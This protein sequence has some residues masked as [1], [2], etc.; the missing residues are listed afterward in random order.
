V[1]F[2]V[3]AY[4][5]E[6]QPGLK[7]GIENLDASETPKVTVT[8]TKLYR[9]NIPSPVRCVLAAI[10]AK[11]VHAFRAVEAVLFEFTP[12][13]N[14]QMDVPLRAPYI[15][16]RFNQ[17]ESVARAD[18]PEIHHQFAQDRLSHEGRAA[19]E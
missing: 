10:L 1:V 4:F 7:K 13:L 2:R 15:I 14:N 18:G 5:P 3:L 17:L 8:L 6:R 19:P 11:I 9:R 16:K 12:A